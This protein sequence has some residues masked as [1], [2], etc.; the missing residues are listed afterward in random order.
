MKNATKR[1]LS[2]MVALALVITS[3][4]LGVLQSTTAKAGSVGKDTT[5][6]FYEVSY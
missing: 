2:C 5:W 4:N 3:L 6:D 1:L